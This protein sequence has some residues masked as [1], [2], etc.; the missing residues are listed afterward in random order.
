VVGHGGAGADRLVVRVGVNENH[1][2]LLRHLITVRPAPRGT[3]RRRPSPGNQVPAGVVSTVR[4]PADPRRSRWTAGSPSAHE[5]VAVPHL[6]H[7]LRLGAGEGASRGVLAGRPVV[8]LASAGRAGVG[9]VKPSQCP[10]S[11]TTVSPCFV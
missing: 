4:V 8:P 3:Y 7:A 2:G 1:A 10:V 9:V 5:A 6:R 11:W